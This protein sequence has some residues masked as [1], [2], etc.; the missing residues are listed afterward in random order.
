MAD[1]EHYLQAATK[2]NTRRSYQFAVDHYEVSWGGFLPSTADSIARYLADQAEVL[3]INTL[4]QRLAALAR[5]HQDQGFPDPTKAPVVKQ[6]L[7]GIRAVHPHQEK[8]AN[9]LQI[10]DLEK[11]VIY[12]DKQIQQTSQRS[13]LL[14]LCRNKA[15]VL[16]G[17]WRAF[18]S[19][20]LTRLRV[21]NIIIKTDIGL[22]IFLPQTKTD[23]NNQGTTYHVPA[24]S[25]LCPVNAYQDWID[26]ALLTE[27]PVFFGV[28]QWG[29]MNDKGMHSNSV[30]PLLRELMQKAGLS[31]TQSYSS[32]SLRRGFASWANANEWDLKSLMQYVGWKDTK[33]ALRYIDINSTSAKERIESALSRETIQVDTPYEIT[34]QND[35]SQPQTRLQLQLNISNMSKYTRGI[36]RTREKIEFHCLRSYQMKKTDNDKRYEVIIPHDSE[37]DLNDCVETLLFEMHSIADNNQCILEALFSN[38]ET[39]QVWE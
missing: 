39:G 5:W 25:R 36:K 6:V 14:P 22:E 16:L 13:I 31:N 24:L 27:G 26:L 7:K 30:I 21:E 20:E 18:R 15:L 11:I 37:E 8:Q 9:P 34:H 12:L 2:N 17:F 1:I 4:K 23:R 28:D 19:D 32:H 33:S 10:T 3:S 35:K 29:N 38:Q